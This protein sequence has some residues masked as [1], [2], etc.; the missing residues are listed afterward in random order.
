MDD[1]PSIIAATPTYIDR[2]FSVEINNTRLSDQ[3]KELLASIYVNYMTA[4]AN[5]IRN[6]K[7]GCSSNED[8]SRIMAEVRKASDE[9]Y[10]V[11]NSI[12]V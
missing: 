5:S 3:Q 2:T 4:R 1:V 12:R 7:S 6:L 9:F 10:R 8:A 11:L